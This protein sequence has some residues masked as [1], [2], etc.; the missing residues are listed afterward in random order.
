[1]TDPMWLNAE[2]DQAHAVVR[3]A[4]L[5]KPAARSGNRCVS[6][7]MGCGE[8]LPRSLPTA[9][10]DHVSRSEYDVT[11][12]CQ[13]CQ[14]GLFAPDADEIAAMAADTTNYGRC[15][16]CGEYRPYE[17]VDVGVGVI[18]GFDCC[19]HEGNLPQCSKTEGGR[20]C[21]LRQDHRHGCAFGAG[22]A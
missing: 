8:P 20:G 13:A 3:D 21:W 22:A 2:I 4:R 10:R 19:T 14:D 7:P 16:V 5:D 6:P 12:L 18:Q 15:G 17:F 1:M 9:F 11:G